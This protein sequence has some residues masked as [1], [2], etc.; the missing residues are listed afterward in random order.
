MR[1]E[2][3][4]RFVRVTRRADDFNARAIA[5]VQETFQSVAKKRMTRNDQNSA[6]VIHK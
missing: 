1:F 2:R 3:G 6:G 5:L 4:N